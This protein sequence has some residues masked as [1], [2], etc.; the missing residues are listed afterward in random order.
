LNE[1]KINY[2][3]LACNLNKKDRNA[4]VDYFIEKPFKV[5]T[6]NGFDSAMVTSGGIDTFEIDSKTMQS[7]LVEGLFFCGEIIDVD[8]DTGGYNIQ[9]AFSTAKIISDFFNGGENN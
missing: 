2:K 5:S 6:V 1:L 4:I 7:K 8:G 3:E 9:F